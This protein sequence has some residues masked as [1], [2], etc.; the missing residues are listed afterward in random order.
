M[1]VVQLKGN[2]EIAL[3]GF[4][5]SG[6]NIVF[7]VINISEDESTIP[8]V[9][10]GKAYDDDKKKLVED[11]EHIALLDIEDLSKT[12]I[13][14]IDSAIRNITAEKFAMALATNLNEIPVADGNLYDMKIN[15]GYH[16]GYNLTL[17]TNAK[18]KLYAISDISL[19]FAFII[20]GFNKILDDYMQREMDKIND[21]EDL[22]YGDE[23]DDVNEE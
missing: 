10:I 1:R 22:D 18:N 21:D 3:A 23:G 13:C 16:N 4:I 2:K 5:D 9:S 15:Y 12:D 11:S 8:T 6:N 7:I 14:I 20:D 19:N 17:S